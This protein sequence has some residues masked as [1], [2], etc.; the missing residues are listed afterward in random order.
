MKVVL[1][2]RRFVCRSGTK[3]FYYCDGHWSW[4]DSPRH[5]TTL[6]EAIRQR[7]W[8]NS[9]YR[10]GRLQ[11]APIVVEVEITDTQVDDHKLH[12]AFIARG[13]DLYEKLP[14]VEREAIYAYINA[15]ME[16]VDEN[17]D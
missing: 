16:F 13:K 2:E 4:E 7:D 14:A 9:D 10:N 15:N 1:G 12:E 17:D 8:A 6:T 3:Y 5:L 11:Y